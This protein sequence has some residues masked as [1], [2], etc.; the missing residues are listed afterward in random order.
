MGPLPIS[1]HSASHLPGY[2][3][4][5]M[6]EEAC[7]YRWGEADM[8]GCDRKP[9]HTGKHVCDCGAYTTHDCKKEER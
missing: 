5:E 9:G 4:N 3:R 8:H 7:E 1:A 2:W 6:E